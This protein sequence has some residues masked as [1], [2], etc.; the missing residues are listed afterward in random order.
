MDDYYRNP[1]ARAALD[2]SDW[3]FLLRQKQESIEMMDKLGQLTM[4]DAMKR[5]LQS[6]R[7]EHGAY[8]E[9]FISSPM[10]SGIGRLMVDPYSLLLYSSHADDVSAIDAKRAQG[11]SLSASIEGVLTERGQR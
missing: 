11:M 7:T 1:A 9:I 2:N 4:D 6:L 3:M 10:G 8:S 5:L